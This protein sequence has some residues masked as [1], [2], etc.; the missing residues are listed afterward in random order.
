MRIR[1]HGRHAPSKL[2]LR[3]KLAL[4]G[5]LPVAGGAM[6]LSPI[7]VQPGDTLS[8]IAADNGVSL[9]SIERANPQIANPDLIYVG[10][11]V[12]LPGPNTVTVGG[13]AGDGMGAPTKPVPVPKSDTSPSAGSVSSSDLAD[14][15]GVPRDFAACVAFRESSNNPKSV[16]SVPGFEGMGGGAYGI[17]DYVWQGSDLNKSG[18]PYD[19]SLAEQ[20]EAFSKL[21]AKYGKQPWTPS[22]GC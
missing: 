4:A 10:Q 7:I 1:S 11:K 3:K 17:M 22:D 2:P 21:Y 16:N 14:V 5:L 18:Q 12:H 13:G 6:A 8:G 19:A 9:S 15:P 20:K